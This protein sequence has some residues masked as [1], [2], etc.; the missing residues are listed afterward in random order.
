MSGRVHPTFRKLLGLAA[1]P[2]RALSALEPTGPEVR[3]ELAPDV[4]GVEDDVLER[5]A[6]LVAPASVGQKL[7]RVLARLEPDAEGRDASPPVKARREVDLPVPTPLEPQRPTVGAK[8]PPE[9]PRGGLPREAMPERR[10]ESQRL[11]ELAGLDAPLRE[12]PPVEQKERTLP[13]APG[14]ARPGRLGVRG[15]RNVHSTETPARRPLPSREEVRERLQQRALR[16]GAVEALKTPVVPGASPRE[17]AEV[18]TRSSQEPVAAESQPA[19]ASTLARPIERALE[20]LESRA[21]SRALPPS[22]T[23]ARGPEV[24]APGPARGREEAPPGGLAGLAARAASPSGGLAGLAARAASG[25]T[26][27]APRARTESHPP[28]SPRANTVLPEPAVPGV[29]A[30]RMEEAKLAQRL[31]RLL[32]REAERAGVSLEGLEP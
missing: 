22:P 20:R 26:T 12:E 21:P 30:E 5:L 11:Q 16:A 31:E 14:E 28:S 24:P 1:A 32:R 19:V 18:L 3:P 23:R 2:G 13:R 9:R 10:V 17:V 7:E 25:G 4:G 29:L 6:S 15:G 8:R 27:A